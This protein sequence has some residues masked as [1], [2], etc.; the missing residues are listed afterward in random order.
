MFPAFKEWQVIVDA[1]GAGVQTLILRKGGIAED[2][3]GF[4]PKAGRFWLFPTHFH[5]QRAR[6]KPAAFAREPVPQSAAAGN[7]TLRF[8]AEVAHHALV[9]DWNVVRRLDPFHLWTEAVIRERYER[10]RPPGIHVLL[11]RVQ[12]LETPLTFPLTKAMGGCRSW[13]ELPYDPAILPS[14]PVLTDA[15]FADCRLQLR[16]ML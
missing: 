3:G 15:A 2:E 5:E 7:A 4:R 11:L 14:R 13:I 9:T 12:R 10:T 16:A 1:L 6:T 8:C